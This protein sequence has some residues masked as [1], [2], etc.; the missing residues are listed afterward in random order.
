MMNN[1]QYLALVV[2]LSLTGFSLNE[3]TAEAAIPDEEGIFTGCVT[4][5]GSIRLID[6]DKTKCSR[7]EKTIT[8]S[9]GQD[10][11]FA[12][13]FIVDAKDKLVSTF[14]ERLGVSVQG[15]NSRFV[16]GMSINGNYYIIPVSEEGFSNSF[17][18]PFPDKNG[19]I[20]QDKY[21]ESTDCTGDYFLRYSGAFA[22]PN[23]KSFSNTRDINDYF[24]NEKKLYEYDASKVVWGELGKEFRSSINECPDP[25]S[26][27]P[28]GCQ[29]YE[30][31]FPNLAFIPSDAY[32]EV[33]DLSNFEPP[34]RLVVD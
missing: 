22:D 11:P 14:V 30:G 26:W 25:D 4:K 17:Y 29:S 28:P 23:I 13:P 19:K 33:A 12:G 5:I 2:T 15:G 7:I 31:T 1:K 10:I 16:A 8:W 24:I 27:S 21:Y 34:F 32:Y 6:A 3:Y 9:Q 18:N 20:C